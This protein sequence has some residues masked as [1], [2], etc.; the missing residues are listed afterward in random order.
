MVGPS[1]AQATRSSTLRAGPVRSKNEDVT[2]TS[3]NPQRLGSPSKSK[4]STP[5]K[6]LKRPSTLT[7]R[8]RESIAYNADLHFI[9]PT[10]P[11]K[12]CPLAALPSELRSLIYSYVFGDL[13]KPVFMNYG[14]I[15]HL[16]AALLQ[17]CRA[18]RIE[19]AYMYYA[20]ASFTWIIKNFNFAL[21]MRWL[22]NLQPSHRALLSRNRSLTIEITPELR[23]SYT[24][25]PKDFLLDDTMLN[26]WKACQP[27]GNLYTV[28]KIRA[29]EPHR[30]LV[31]MLDDPEA[32]HT[33]GKVFFVLFCRLAAW[34]K[35]C[36]QSTF[37]DID[38]KYKFEM[39]S[40]AHGRLELYYR[41]SN[42][43]PDI[44]LF[45]FKLKNF[46]ARNHCENR[47]RQP[48]LR[49]FDAFLEAFG[50]L[51]DSNGDRFRDRRLFETLNLQRERIARWDRRPAE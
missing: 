21:V 29:S 46:W 38:W 10:N 16:P 3:E 44:Q 47:I 32:L 11:S 51:E 41:I 30:G 12:L 24:Y 23:R 18:I 17:I 31:P 15:R 43:L 5:T 27:F 36:T 45:L 6:R 35:L 1:F 8:A 14:R 7:K 40:D 42:L 48:I 20:E 19:A 50:N 34:S 37:N 13:K 26:H 49:L 9:K 39:P 33:Q 25:P 28:T 4:G 2:S 22:Q